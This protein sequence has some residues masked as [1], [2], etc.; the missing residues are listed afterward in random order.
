MAFG[1]AT[2]SGS[3]TLT[4]SGLAQF[5]P[6]RLK[7]VPGWNVANAPRIHAAP[8][9]IADESLSSWLF[10][11]SRQFG[12]S[13]RSM[14]SDVG[15]I[16]L[17]SQLNFGLHPSIHE[18]FVVVFP[19]SGVGEFNAVRGRT[20]WLTTKE[21]AFLTF[22]FPRRQALCRYCPMCIATAP[23][24]HLRLRD[25]IASNYLCK[26]HQCA[27]R[28]FCP[29][30]YGAI[31]LDCLSRESIDEGFRR[32]LCYCQWCGD[33]L[34]ARG[35]VH[36]PEDLRET[37]Y[38]FQKRAW[39]AIKTPMRK[40]S[41]RKNFIPDHVQDLVK[42]FRRSPRCVCGV[43]RRVLFASREERQ[44]KSAD[45]CSVGPRNTMSEWERAYD[46]CH[47]EAD[48]R[49]PY[50]IDA[51]KCF[52]KDATKIAS[53]LANAQFL[54]GSTAWWSQKYD[55]SELF[56]LDFSGTTLDDSAARAR[57][58]LSEHVLV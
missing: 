45:G 31:D 23:T 49:A 15:L 16:G 7:Q 30:C 26:E 36:L 12:C 46:S 19:N 52:G 28:E 56:P 1:R 27:I 39:R 41:R 10:R 37:L 11:V 40:L 4:A 58:W 32:E 24:P 2:N 13:P 18:R 9:Y 50:A 29:N 35:V 57:A 5:L 25:Q 3:L 33:D 21:L 54:N 43:R 34:R 20:P 8:K 22:A 48:G 38:A 44:A 47:C 55:E 14:L 53:Y 51:I 17:P 42:L 6:P